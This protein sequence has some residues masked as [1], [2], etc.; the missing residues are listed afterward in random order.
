MAAAAAATL[1]KH[2]K[3]PTTFSINFS[4]LLLLKVFL[5]WFLKKLQLN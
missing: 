3:F 2:F 1:P 5:L 4:L